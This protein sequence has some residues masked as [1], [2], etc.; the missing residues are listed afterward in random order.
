MAFLSV[1]VLGLIVAVASCGSGSIPHYSFKDPSAE[2]IK[3]AIRTTV[4]LAYAASVAMSSVTGSVPPN[5]AFL[6]NSCTTT[7]T[8]CSAVITINDDN[9]AWPLQFSSFGTITVYGYWIS[10]DEAILTVA[11]GNAAGSSLFPV[12]DI[13]VFPV[14]RTATGFTIVYVNVD[15]D[16]S[17]GPVYPANLT[18]AE[19]QT[20]IA[21]LN[22][23]HSNDASVN[24]DMDAWVINVDNAGT[25][26]LSDDTY[27]IYGG[28]QYIEAGSGA[29]SALQLGMGAVAIG[30]D[31]SLNPNAGFAVLNA[32]ENSSSNVVLANAVITF[33]STTCDGKAMVLA[34]TGNYLLAIGKSI[35]LNLTSP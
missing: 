11:F 27:S 25:Q 35:P 26:T 5:A 21:L 16:I 14:L 13:S 2:P 17:T 9:S 34:A 31:C 30:P 6:I 10:P 24:V 32:F 29:E 18:L 12:H 20:Q 3:A 33:P 7:P 1:A 22:T 15:V 23:Q 8:D 4:P 28:G 19:R